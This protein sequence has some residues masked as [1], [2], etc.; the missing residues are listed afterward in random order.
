MEREYR[1]SVDMKRNCKETQR[2]YRKSG[3]SSPNSIHA[4]KLGSSSWLYFSNS[5]SRRPVRAFNLFFQDK[6]A[7]FIKEQKTVQMQLN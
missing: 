3:C 6:Y 1:H 5:S 4:L 2:V 7:M